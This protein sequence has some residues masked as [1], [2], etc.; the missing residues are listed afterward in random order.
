MKHFFYYIYFR[1][2]T[3]SEKREENFP[4]GIVVTWLS[5]MM[6]FNLCTLL[7][8]V[9]ICFGVDA[10]SVFRVPRTRFSILLGFSVFGG[11]LWGFLKLFHVKEKAFSPD[12]IE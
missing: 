6:F 2:Y 7:S 8:L 12:M 10:G 5:L 4:G 9:T 3:W 1:L 11:V